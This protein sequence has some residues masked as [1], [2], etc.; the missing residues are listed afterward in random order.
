MAFIGLVCRTGEIGL[1]NKSKPVYKLKQ[2]SP[3]NSLCFEQEEE[4]EEEEGDEVKFEPT[5]HELTCRHL[6]SLKDLASFL[7]QL[8]LRSSLFNQ[9]FNKHPHYILYRSLII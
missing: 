9:T 2:E 3:V 5:V 6:S 1:S 8:E 7:Q 4:E